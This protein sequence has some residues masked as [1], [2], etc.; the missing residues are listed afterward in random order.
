M[1]KNRPFV[2]GFAA[3]T[4]NIE[5]YAL[6]KL[7]SK[8]LDMICANDVSSPKQ[9]FNADNNALTLYWQ[10]GKLPLPLMDKNELAQQLIIE[11]IKHYNEHYN[12]KKN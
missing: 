3:E 10:T 6:K 1:K 5:Q 2:V 7:I 8:N 12:E 4:N 9:G 11:I